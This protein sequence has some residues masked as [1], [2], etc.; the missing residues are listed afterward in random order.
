MDKSEKKVLTLGEILISEDQSIGVVTQI[1]N[2]GTEAMIDLI[3]EKVH[4]N[5]DI[6]LTGQSITDFDDS[7]DC[8]YVQD[9]I[10]R[11]EEDRVNNKRFQQM[12]KVMKNNT[13]MLKMN[14]KMLKI[15]ENKF[16]DN[17]I[18]FQMSDL[19]TLMKKCIIPTELKNV[20]KYPEL[21]GISQKQLYLLI[22]AVAKKNDVTSTNSNENVLM[23]SSFSLL[24]MNLNINS[25]D[26]GLFSNLSLIR[27]KL[28]HPV[29]QEF[30]NKSLMIIYFDQFLKDANSL[31][32]GNEQFINKNRIIHLI[33]TIKQL[34][35]RN[36]DKICQHM[37]K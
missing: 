16:N 22:S 10:I 3:D 34:Y 15:H 37:I 12:E 5:Q 7:C 24:L 26:L 30:K 32:S 36:Y 13:K 14:T 9:V 17:N 33:K 25:N 31:N 1:K 23:H 11:V 20:V 28:G 29:P 4:P 18:Y 2:V 27:N 19:Y 6:K 8:K 35:L 21:T